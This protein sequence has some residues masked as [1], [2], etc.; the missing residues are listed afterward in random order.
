MRPL[1][2]G[3]NVTQFRGIALLSRRVKNSNRKSANI[4]VQNIIICTLSVS[5]VHVIQY[6]IYTYPPVG[7]LDAPPLNCY[8]LLVGNPCLW[9]LPGMYTFDMLIYEV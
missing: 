2:A 7:R 8:V 9:Y 3:G 5:N 4:Y 6:I 1:S